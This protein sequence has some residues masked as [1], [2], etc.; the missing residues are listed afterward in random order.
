M[1]EGNKK[2]QFLVKKVC[3]SHGLVEENE[4]SVDL[5][6][7]NILI[8]HKEYLRIPKNDFKENIIKCLQIYFTSDSNSQSSQST[9]EPKGN[10]IMSPKLTQI[11]KRKRPQSADQLEP[12]LDENNSTTVC[13]DDLIFYFSDL[14]SLCLLAHIV[15]PYSSPIHSSIESCWVR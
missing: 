3:T 12:P 9:K 5:V 13:F 11:K 6:M 2:L 14:V 15:F 4:E 7:K 1:S 10:A 8:Q